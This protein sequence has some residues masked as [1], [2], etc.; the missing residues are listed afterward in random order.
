MVKISPK[1]LPKNSYSLF[2][3]SNK[4][5]DTLKSH[6]SALFFEETTSFSLLSKYPLLNSHVILHKEEAFIGPSAGLIMHPNE[7]KVYRNTPL[8]LCIT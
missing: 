5:C 4:P 6:F 2:P 7:S 8:A 1:V 3:H